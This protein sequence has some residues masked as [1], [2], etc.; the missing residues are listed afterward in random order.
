MLVDTPTC[1]F[2]KDPTGRNQLIRMLMRVQRSKVDTTQTIENQSTETQDIYV[3]NPEREKPRV[4]LSC[5]PLMFFLYEKSMCLFPC[6]AF[7]VFISIL[8]IQPFV[9]N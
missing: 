5:D 2:V 7:L 1:F 6:E 4:Q 9:E 3:E 8:I